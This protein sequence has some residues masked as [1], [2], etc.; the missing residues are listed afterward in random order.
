[1]DELPGTRGLELPAPAADRR[2]YHA[3]QAPELDVEPKVGLI[4]FGFDAGAHAHPGWQ[5]HLQRLKGEIA[6]VVVL[7]DA[8]AIR[9]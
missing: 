8:K 6:H 3:Q 4:I 1:M 9:V 7:G 2:S 5:R